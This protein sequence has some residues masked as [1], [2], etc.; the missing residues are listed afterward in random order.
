[1]EIID[2]L[3]KVIMKDNCPLRGFHDFT[4]MM[5]LLKTTDKNI[6][7]VNKRQLEIV[8]ILKKCKFATTADL[9][10]KLKVTRRTLRY[11]IA[12]LK[13]VY[14]DNIITRRGNGGGIEWK[15]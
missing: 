13:R 6:H 9:Q 15:E 8:N 1:M 12:Y 3:E 11:D 10:E 2:D 14:P 7:G 4:Y 5:S